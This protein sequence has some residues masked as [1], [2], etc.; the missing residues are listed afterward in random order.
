M[1]SLGTNAG[2]IS[3]V[4]CRGATASPRDLSP[5]SSPLAPVTPPGELDA[6]SPRSGPSSALPTFKDQEA[7]DKGAAPLPLPNRPPSY[8][9]A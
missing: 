9:D 5:S 7:G 1:G 3:A 6:A 8:Q 4:M 2:L